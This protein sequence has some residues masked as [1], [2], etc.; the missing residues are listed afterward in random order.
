MTVAIKFAN[1]NTDYP[2]GGEI[3][4]KKTSHVPQ[5]NQE[6]ILQNQTVDR[7]SSSKRWANSGFEFIGQI[8]LVYFVHFADLAAIERYFRHRCD[9]DGVHYRGVHYRGVDGLSPLRWHFFVPVELVSWL[10]VAEHFVHSPIAVDLLVHHHC[11]DDDV[12]CHGDHCHDG[13]V[14]DHRFLHLNLVE[15]GAWLSEVAV[16]SHSVHFAIVHFLLVH[17]HCDDDGVH[18]RG[19]HCHDDD[20]LS[21]PL[22]W[23][24]FV[25]VALVVWR[26]LPPL[27]KIPPPQK[28]E[29]QNKLLQTREQRKS[30]Q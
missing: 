12:H 1:S 30:E 18:Y 7:S 27:P 21:P 28:M 13:D 11:D 15:L 14:P 26:R 4:F 22:R 3:R 29:K 20:G 5:V 23:H 2:V 10:F 6:I 25:P 17:H 16:H 8:V 24:F 9:D 19:V